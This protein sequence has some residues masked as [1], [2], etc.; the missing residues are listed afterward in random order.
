M[1][2]NLD[3][4]MYAS[5]IY[6]N[7]GYYHIELSPEAKQIC[8]IVLPW[9]K[10]ECQKLPLGVCNSPIYSKKIHPKYLMVLTWSGY[11]D[12]VLVITKKL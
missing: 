3:G 11:I 10:Y 6:L 5:S 12:D 4:F 9:G 8:T 7:M 1:L 2:L